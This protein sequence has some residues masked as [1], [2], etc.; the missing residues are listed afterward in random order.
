MTSEGLGDM[1]EGDSADTRAGKFPLTSIGGPSRGSRVCRP[2][3][4]D[5]HQ[6]E[7]K[8]NKHFTRF[9]FFLIAFS[10]QSKFYSFVA[11]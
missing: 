2:G 11:A 8:F 1:F 7:R 10:L 3:S 9:F 6:R 5:P 4:E